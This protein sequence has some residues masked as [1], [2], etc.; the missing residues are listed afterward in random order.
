ME[1]CFNPERSFFAKEA[2]ETK[3]QQ[4]PISRLALLA[5]EQKSSMSQA[6]VDSLFAKLDTPVA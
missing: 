2:N 4:A 1:M 3:G 6:E 5:Q